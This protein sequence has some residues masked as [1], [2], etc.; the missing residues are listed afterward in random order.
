MIME[1]IMAIG[2]E[3]NPRVLE[4]KLKSF[5]TPSARKGRLVSLRRIQ[6]K[7]RIESED[8]LLSYSSTEAAGPSRAQ[9]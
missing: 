7:F 8:G 3:L 9:S 2:S 6:E 5:L 4:M 1:G